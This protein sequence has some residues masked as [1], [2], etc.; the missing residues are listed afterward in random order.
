MFQQRLFEYLY[1][2]NIDE[3]RIIFL[4]QSNPELYNYILCGG[5]ITLDS[6]PFGGGV[7]LSDSIKCNIPFITLPSYQVS[8]FI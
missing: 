2:N 1:Q 8:N 5:D 7:T 4:S 6:F 3:R